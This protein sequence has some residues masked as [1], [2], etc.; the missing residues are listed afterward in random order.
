MM[1]GIGLPLVIVL[2]GLIV[3]RNSSGRSFTAHFGNVSTDSLKRQGWWVVNADTE[4]LKR[5]GEI[6]MIRNLLVHRVN[7]NCWTMEVH[8]KDF[9]PEQN[10]PQAGLLLMEDTGFH[11]KNIRV[12]LAYNDYNG[13]YP[14]SGPIILRAIS[15]PGVSQEKPEE[16]AHAVLFPVDSLRNGVSLSRDMANPALR[17]EKNGERIRILYADGIPANT[18]FREISSHEFPFRPR[19]VGLFAIRGFVDSAKALPAWFSY[20]KLDCCEGPSAP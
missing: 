19:F 6:P 15:S 5:R 7:C 20:F 10:W 18:S 13:V 8:F 9:I 12:S 4:N 3:S 2:V 17:I 1:A 11:G 16:F 14:R